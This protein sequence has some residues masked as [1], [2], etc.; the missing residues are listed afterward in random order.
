MV[1]SSRILS[2]VNSSVNSS[3]SGL[4]QDLV[5]LGKRPLYKLI[6]TDKADALLLDAAIALRNDTE[7]VLDLETKNRLVYVRDLQDL[8][9]VREQLDEIGVDFG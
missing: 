6:D 4:F 9:W 1:I 8:S 3:S 7:V 2:S 5:F